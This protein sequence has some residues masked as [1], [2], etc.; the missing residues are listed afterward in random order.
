VSRF[1]KFSV[2]IAFAATISAGAEFIVKQFEV[3]NPIRKSKR[4][5]VPGN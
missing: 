5:R 2:L 3:G 4:S 1:P